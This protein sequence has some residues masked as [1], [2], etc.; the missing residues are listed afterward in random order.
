VTG[1]DA[2][3]DAVVSHQALNRAQG[4]ADDFVQNLHAEGVADQLALLLP[5]RALARH[6]ASAQQVLH[7]AKASS[8]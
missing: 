4:D 2:R 5:Q 6:Q 3:R 7:A 1:R 8:A